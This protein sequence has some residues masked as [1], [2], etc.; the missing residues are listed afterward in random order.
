MSSRIVVTNPVDTAVVGTYTV[1]YN[2]TDL[3]GNA[4]APVTRSV[5]VQVQEGTGGGGGGSIGAELL[6]LLAL[7]LR[8]SKRDVAAIPETLCYQWLIELI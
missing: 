6:V 3:S 5:R 7:P 8:C 1:T 2:A 4:A